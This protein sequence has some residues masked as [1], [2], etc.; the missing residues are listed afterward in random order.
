[1]TSTDWPPRPPNRVRHSWRCRV[2]PYDEELRE[3]PNRQ[4][5][6][7]TVCEECGGTDLLDRIRT[8]HEPT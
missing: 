6:V 5:L 8:E 1:M 3:L 2:G 4:A 7:V